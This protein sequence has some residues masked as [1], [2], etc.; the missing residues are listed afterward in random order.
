MEIRTYKE[1][2]GS[3]TEFEEFVFK[4]FNKLYY[5]VEKHD[6]DSE[7][8]IHALLLDPIKPINTIQ[9]KRKFQEFKKIHTTKKLRNNAFHC[10]VC[11]NEP[12]FIRYLRACKDGGS[13]EF[14]YLRHPY[15]LDRV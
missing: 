13:K 12:R 10:S 1:Y 15:Y 9:L 3:L 14:Y 4:S 5:C 7:E 11:L 8:H 2:I 6:K